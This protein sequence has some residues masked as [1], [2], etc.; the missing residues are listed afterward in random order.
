MQAEKERSGAPDLPG[1]AGKRYVEL[2]YAETSSRQLRNQLRKA[3]EL[4]CQVTALLIAS[5]KKVDRGSSVYLLDRN[6]SLAPDVAKNL[7][8]KGFKNCYVVKG[9][10]DGWTRAKLQIRPSIAVTN[11]E[12]IAP[13]LG[14]IFGSGS[15]SRTTTT[16]KVIAG[17]ARNGGRRALPPGK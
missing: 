15:T 14:T 11:A 6:G 7:D 13:V 12:V 9:G 2:E 8:S 4:E 1:P 16:P 3:N 10:Y 17:N 5:L